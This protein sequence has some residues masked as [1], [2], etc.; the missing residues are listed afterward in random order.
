MDL[1]IIWSR[2]GPRLPVQGHGSLASRLFA[3]GKLQPLQVTAKSGRIVTR[4][5]WARANAIARLESARIMN[6]TH[7]VLGTRA[8][9]D[10]AVWRNANPQDSRTTDICERASEHAPMS[11][12]EWSAS[13][14]GR[15]PRVIPFHLCRSFLVAG[16]PEWFES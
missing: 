10:D 7:E 12:E 14:F 5:V 8:L 3:G 2:L 15:P 1:A 9:G 13:E 11:L 16:L 4:S 6:G